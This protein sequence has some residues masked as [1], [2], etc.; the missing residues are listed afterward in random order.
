MDMK[1]LEVLLPF[2]WLKAE[3]SATGANSLLNLQGKKLDC[4]TLKAVS[5]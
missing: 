4:G 5:Y 1:A 2:Y 3:T